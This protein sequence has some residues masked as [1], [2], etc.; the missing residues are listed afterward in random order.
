MSYR[1]H[2][3]KN[4]DVNNTVRRYGADTNKQIDSDTY[5]VLVSVQ[6]QINVDGPIGDCRSLVVLNVCVRRA[7][8]RAEA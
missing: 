8:E 3:E 2:R 5:V 4:S 1:A 7:E 6:R